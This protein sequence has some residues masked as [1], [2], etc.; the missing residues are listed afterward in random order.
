MAI[1]VYPAGLP[2]NVLL[3]GYMEVGPTLTLR[4]TMDAGPPKMRRRFTA[5][6][7]PITGRELIQVNKT[8]DQKS[9]L[10]NFY[11]NILLCTLVFQW[12]TPVGQGAPPT[13]Q[14]ALFRFTKP[15][16]YKAITP[17]LFDTSFDLEIMP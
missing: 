9:I 2:T 17:F 5:G 4:T 16:T 14:V 15:P 8:I 13:P 7:R 6:V 3:A 11:Y 1:P 10:E 12:T